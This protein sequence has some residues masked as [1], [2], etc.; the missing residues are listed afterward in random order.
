MIFTR[1]SKTSAKKGKDRLKLMLGH[2]R[3]ENSLHGSLALFK[4]EFLELLQKHFT[5]DPIALESLNIG[6]NAESEVPI[7]EI[8]AELP[9][10]R[11]RSL[12]KKL[13]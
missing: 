10:V 13:L 7:L 1:K 12:K 5:I 2:D 6:L 11:S 3:A 9:E 8:S 4:Q